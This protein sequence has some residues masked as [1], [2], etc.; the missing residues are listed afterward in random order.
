MF[1]FRKDCDWMFILGPAG[2]VGTAPITT[3]SNK[4]GCSHISATMLGITWTEKWLGYELTGGP[5]TWPPKLPDLTP[6]DFFLVKNKVK[7]N[8]LQHL[9]AHIG[10]TVSWFFV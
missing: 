8:Y 9:K 5:I 6:L 3:S 7:I 1:L 10:D 4:M 2:A